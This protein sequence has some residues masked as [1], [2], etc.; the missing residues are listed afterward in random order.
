M[1]FTAFQGVNLYDSSGSLMWILGNYFLSRFYSIY[2]SRLNRIGLAQSITYESVQALPSS[3]FR[4]SS[5]RA[6]MSTLSLLLISAVLLFIISYNWCER[7]EKQTAF[8]SSSSYGKGAVE[9][10]VMLHP[11]SSNQVNRHSTVSRVAT[12]PCWATTCIWIPSARAHERRDKAQKFSN[13]N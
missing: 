7:I 6:N 12:L 11:F 3:L 5:E 9:T 13:A 8:Q 10:G 1:C 2:D 4:S